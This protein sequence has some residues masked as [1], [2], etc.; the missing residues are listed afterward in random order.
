[1]P[2]L[3]TYKKGS[4][5]GEAQSNNKESLNLT[6]FEDLVYDL[7]GIPWLVGGI[8]VC[9]FLSLEMEAVAPTQHQ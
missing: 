2:P 9:S 5:K 1:M 6:A 8:Q 3:F 7:V 4:E